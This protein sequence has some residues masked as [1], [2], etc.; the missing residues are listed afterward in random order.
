MAEQQQRFDEFTRLYNGERP[1]AALDGDTPADHYKPSLRG[2]PEA[3]REVEY[4][5]GLQLRKAD[6]DGKIRWKQ[7]RCRVG[8]ALAHEVIGVE[9]LDDGVSRV[10]FGPVLLGLL[11][12]RKGYSGASKKGFSQW[13]PLQSPSGPAVRKRP[14]GSPESR[15]IRAV[16]R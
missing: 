8:S 6:Q 12:E 16:V 10:W 1:H 15:L 11:D 7:A 2:F 3:L 14:Y 9:E 4:P 5:A 13:P